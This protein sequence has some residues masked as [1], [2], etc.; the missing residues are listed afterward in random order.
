[1]P[2]LGR[3]GTYL[4]VRQVAQHV[5][6]FWSYFDVAT[7]DQAGQSNPAEC[8]KLASKLVGRWP[9]GAPMALTPTADDPNRGDENDF[10]YKTSDPAGMGC[11]F[12]S[13]IR[14]SNPPRHP[15]RQP[16]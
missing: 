3:N 12:G 9:S 11:P 7:K 15:R 2:D 8:A 1:M 5:P 14:R 4:V 10:L 13:H 16:G 6:Q